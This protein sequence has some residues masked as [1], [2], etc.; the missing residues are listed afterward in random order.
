MRS[1]ELQRV[2]GAKLA[3]LFGEALLRAPQ[4]R[5][6]LRHETSTSSTKSPGSPFKQGSAP[7]FTL[8]LG[9]QW[10]KAVFFTHFLEDL[11]IDDEALP[12]RQPPR[13][14]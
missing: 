1:R 10:W 4:P 12:W 7:Q 11:Q 13:Q 5:R 3:A 9:A 14:S 8:V 6:S 2:L